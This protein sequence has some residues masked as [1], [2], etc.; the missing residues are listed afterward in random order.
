[1]WKVQTTFL[2][3]FNWSTH[4]LELECHEKMETLELKLFDS[5]KCWMFFSIAPGGTIWQGVDH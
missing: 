2:E 1:M 4:L 3:K 5:L